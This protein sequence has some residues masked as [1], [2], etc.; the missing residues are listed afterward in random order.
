MIKKNNFI[1]MLIIMAFFF[2]SGL[3]YEVDA[4]TVKPSVHAHSYVIMDSKSGQIIDY[5]DKD[6]RIYPAST[7]KM[8]TALVALEKGSLSQKI[9]VKENVLS[10]IPDD[11]TKVGLKAGSTYTLDQLLHMLLISSAA[12]ASDTIADALG[13]SV[14]NFIS[15][16]NKKAK[17]LGMNNTNFDN[18]IGLDIGDGFNNTYSTANDIAKL[19]REV[20]KNST[21]RQI[22]A[23]SSYTISKFNGGSSKTI[24]NTNRFLR[25]QWYPKDK[26]KIIGTKTGSTNAAGYVLST[27]SIDNSGREIICSFFG[28][29]TRTKMYE[30]IQSLLTYTYNNLSINIGWKQVGQK[31]YYYN[32]YGVMQTGWLLDEA[33]RWFYLRS[34]GEMATGWEQVGNKWYYLSQTGVMQ[35]GWLLDETNRWFYLRSNGEMATIKS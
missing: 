31:W 22:V 13:G 21:I 34:N 7:V 27:T 20:M 17:S 26:Y 15:L 10:S 28:N 12:D 23:K 19:T 32:Q 29:S 25:D 11:A 6:K 14:S 1:Y 24:N 33:N 4:S 30:D 35:T 3:N 16:M 9:T 5:Q 18:S 8:M 2:M